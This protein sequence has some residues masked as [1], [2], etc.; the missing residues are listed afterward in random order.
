PELNIT[1][2]AN[3]PGT[4]VSDP[5]ERL[6]YYRGMSSAQS[7]AQIDEW[8]ADLQ[9]RFGSLPEP[10]QNLAAVFKLKRR[11]S[12]LQVQRAD[13]FAN[14]LVVHWTEDS[15]PLEPEAFLAWLQSQQ[16]Q[17]K[18]DPPAKLELRFED[19]A[20]ISRAIQEAGQMLDGLLTVP[21]PAG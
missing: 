2:E 4:Y 18:F 19:K 14:R 1:F 12:A 6:Q 11:L 7:D 5:Q 15:R 17:V 20:S 3:I 13:L 16:N 8:V 10:V 21:A 9:D